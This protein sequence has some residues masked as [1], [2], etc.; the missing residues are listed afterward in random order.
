M[1]WFVL[2]V[3]LACGLSARS[4]AAAPPDLG[5]K[6]LVVFVEKCGECHGPN[7]KKIKKFGYVDDLPRMAANPKLVVPGKPDDSSMWTTVEDGEMP[8]EESP[9]L[10][11]DEKQ[12]IHDWVKFG[13]PPAAHPPAIATTTAS[14]Q[15]GISKSAGTAAPA[16]QRSLGKRA[17][18]F[19]GR[20]H[21]VVVHFPIALLIAAVAFELGW[22]VL[23]VHWL[24]GAVRGSLIL[25]AAGA[26][27]GSALGLVD[28]LS[29]TNSELL[30]S[31]RNMGLIG[32]AWSIVTLIVFEI[33]T[34]SRGIMD[35]PAPW[36]GWGRVGFRVVLILGAMLIGWVGHLGG[37][38]VYG[39]DFLSF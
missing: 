5:D 1:K 30:Q 13:A 33:G 19:L 6:V 26:I 27:V 29:H 12:L 11:A 21:P 23:R 15:P 36:R 10:T 2:I 31:H 20:L 9:Q 25:G 8:P 24:D 4:F 18:R 17:V 28:A 37:A 39:E 35:P 34:R 22:L 14:T 16:P 32:T 38:L 7:A 3:I